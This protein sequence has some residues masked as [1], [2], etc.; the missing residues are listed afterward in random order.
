MPSRFRQ[1]IAI[2]LVPSAWLST[3]PSGQLHVAVEDAD[4]VEPEE[5]ALEDVVAERVLAV[6][7]PVEVQEQLVED[8]LEERPVALARLRPLDL[9]DAQGGPGVDGRVHVGEVPLVRG[10]LAVGVHVPLAQHQDE[11]VLGELRVHE[12]QDDAVER[13]VPR[14]VPRELP[15]VGH[16]EDVGVEDV[17]PVAVAAGLAGGGRGRLERV[18]VEP[19]PDVVLVELLGPEHPGERLP[20]D[21][22]LFGRQALRDDGGVELVGLG[23]AQRQNRGRTPRPSGSPAGRLGVGQAQAHARAAARGDRRGGGAPRPWCP[24]GPG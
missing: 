11:L 23:A 8:A 3:Q 22:L 7:P 2:Q 19:A 18:A 12:R 10:D 4:V 21:V 24:G 16:R 14:G 9:E 1:Y 13:E 15:R 17:A 20:H 6:D 5:A